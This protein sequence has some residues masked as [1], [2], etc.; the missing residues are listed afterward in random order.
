MK[1][2]E[3]YICEICGTEYKEKRVCEECEKG[4]HKPVKIEGAKWTPMKNNRSGYPTHIHIKMSNGETIVY[5][6]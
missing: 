6:R 2:I 5:K 1:K 3:H 4:H